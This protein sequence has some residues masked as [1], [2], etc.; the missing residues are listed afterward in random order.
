[1]TVKAVDESIIPGTT[2]HYGTTHEVHTTYRGIC[3]SYVM[4]WSNIPEHV[5]CKLCLRILDKP[6]YM[7]L[8]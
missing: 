5:T 7:R 4:S 8:K 1:M 2:V 3:K 6:A